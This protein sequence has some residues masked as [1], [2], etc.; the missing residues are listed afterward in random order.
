MLE[1]SLNILIFKRKLCATR[2][3]DENE[4]KIPQI[5]TNKSCCTLLYFGANDMIRAFIS[6]QP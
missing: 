4:L 3:A 1:N 2:K 5:L 6:D